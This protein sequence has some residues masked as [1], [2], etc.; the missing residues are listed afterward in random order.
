M[1]ALQGFPFYDKPLR[2]VFAKSKSRAVELKDGSYKRQKKKSRKEVGER[3]KVH[4]GPPQS[5]EAEKEKTNVDEMT[6]SK[7]TP[8]IETLEVKS[9]G[10]KG[11]D[12]ATPPGPI[13]MC[14][15]L[16]EKCTK[17]M[18]E[19]LFKQFSGL[20]DIR[21]IDGK[22]LAFIEYADEHQSA[23]ALEALQNFRFSRTESLHLSYAK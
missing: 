13:I 3:K 14:S 9:A 22:R 18:L 1:K 5:A 2:I 8:P 4:I 23:V 21:L 20:Q 11:N 10:G 12:G 15:D 7:T 17:A 19:T 6:K 16:P